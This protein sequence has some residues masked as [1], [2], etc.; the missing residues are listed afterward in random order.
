MTKTMTL[1]WERDSASDKP[2]RVGRTAVKMPNKIEVDDD[3]SVTLVAVPDSA[4]T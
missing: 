1:W 2:R 4:C 3:R